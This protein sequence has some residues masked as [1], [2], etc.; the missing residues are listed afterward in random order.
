MLE[1]C[2]Q[3]KFVETVTLLEFDRQSSSFNPLL[4]QS[5]ESSE[6]V[7]S[8]LVAPSGRGVISKEKK[9]EMEGS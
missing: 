3:S 6:D 1:L 2:C 7:L 9:G 8:R 5:I 4:H